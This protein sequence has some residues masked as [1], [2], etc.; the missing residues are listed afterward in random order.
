[1]HVRENYLEK[2]EDKDAGKVIIHISRIAS[3]FYGT[4]QNLKFGL[5]LGRFAVLKKKLGRL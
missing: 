3:N 2:E 4:A 1:M 5:V